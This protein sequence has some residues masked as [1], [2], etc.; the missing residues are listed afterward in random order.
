VIPHIGPQLAALAALCAPEDRGAV[1]GWTIDRWKI[2]DEA[3]EALLD[4]Y[5]AL[6][7]GG[8]EAEI[9]AS[10]EADGI[11]VSALLIDDDAARDVITRSD[12]TELAAAAA[13]VGADGWPQET[14]HLPNV[15]KGSRARSEVGIDVLAVRMDFESDEVELGPG[16]MLFIGSVKHTVEDPADC[17]YKLVRSVSPSDLTLPYVGQQLRVLS[18]HLMAKGIRARRVYLFLRGFPDGQRVAIT[19]TGAIDSTLEDEFFD[20]M[21]NLPEADG[22]R[23]CRHLVF[24]GLE[25]LHELTEDD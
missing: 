25:D 17:R 14:M 4:V 6:L 9:E 8:L 24:D 13:A 1:R 20:Q 19:I 11:D 15:P 5:E 22:I 12:L 10:L 18:G 21:A 23:H 3:L 2:D 7:L 16:E